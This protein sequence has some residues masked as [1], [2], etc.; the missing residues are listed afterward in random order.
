MG[1][2]TAEKLYRMM[3]D[4]SLSV[5]IMDARSL[6][7]FEESQIHVPGQNCISV[8]EEAISPGWVL[9]PLSSA[10]PWHGM[11]GSLSEPVETTSV[12]IM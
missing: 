7:D 11:P 9:L 4:Q 1:G 2:I 12:L 5:I 10:Q 8:P 6:R 3:M